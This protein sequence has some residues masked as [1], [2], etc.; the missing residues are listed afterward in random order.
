[1]RATRPLLTLS[2]AGIAQK[3]KKTGVSTISPGV[4]PQLPARYLPDGHLLT[5][6]KNTGGRNNR[7]W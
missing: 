2:A 4:V 5:A 6:K 3:F 7:G 1:M